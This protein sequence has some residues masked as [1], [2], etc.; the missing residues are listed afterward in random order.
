LRAGGGGVSTEPNDGNGVPA[1]I[2][3]PR[4]DH[5][6][7]VTKVKVKEEIWIGFNE[8]KTD[9]RLNI[10]YANKFEGFLKHVDAT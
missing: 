2:Q 1:G 8:Y 6:K 4:Y 10:S 3:S 5:N 7:M 9:R